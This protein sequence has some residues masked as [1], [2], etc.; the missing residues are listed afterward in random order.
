MT[1]QD[2]AQLIEQQLLDPAVSRQDI[3]EACKQ[4]R[5]HGFCS[6]WVN[7]SCVSH[8]VALL[9]GSDVKVAT[10]VGFPLGAMDS[11]AKRY[12]TEVAID[13]GGQEINV[14]LNFGWMKGG[15]HAIVLRELRDVVEAADERPVGVILESNILTRS[16]KLRA[17]ELAKEAGAK[18]VITGSILG[19]GEVPA[20]EVRLLHGT[21][22]TT[23]GVIAAGQIRDAQVA[24][25]LVEA[26]ASRITTAEGAAILDSLRS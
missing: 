25:A 12:E 20:E 23:F 2:L 13:N 6:L 22:G 9:E 11:D 4:A 3:Q 5:Q 15:E 8:A 14:V 24:V 1:R 16:E 21:M 7:G 26:G 17:C 10:V 19:A 18:S